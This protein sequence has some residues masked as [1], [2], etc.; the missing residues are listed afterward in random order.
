LFE[1][2]VGDETARRLCQL[3]SGHVLTPEDLGAHIDTAVMQAFLFDGPTTIVAMSKQRT[4]RGALRKAIPVRD[5]RCQHR[6]V[7]PKPAVDGD[8][9]HRRPAARGGPTSQFNGAIRCW[10]HNR[11]PELHDHDGEPRPERVLTMLDEFRCRIRW[12]LLRD[13]ENDPEFRAL[14]VDD[15]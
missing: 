11:N 2:I 9:D 3:A 4:F 10:P 8:V 13:Q 6:S 12:A 5:R 15:D 7:C 14:F 1:V